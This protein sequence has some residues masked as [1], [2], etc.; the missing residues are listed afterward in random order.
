MWV[1]NNNTGQSLLSIRNFVGQIKQSP[2]IIEFN[3]SQ[4]AEITERVTYPQLEM[5]IL[6]MPGEKNYLN[7]ILTE[8]SRPTTYLT[9]KGKITV[10][11]D[12]ELFDFIMDHTEFNDYIFNLFSIYQR[13][14]FLRYFV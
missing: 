8:V 3:M 11:F 6:F 2:D 5:H 7:S 13:L 4:I 1:I 9:S 12:I 14:I 10:D